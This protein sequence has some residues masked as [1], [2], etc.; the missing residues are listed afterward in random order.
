[1]IFFFDARDGQ[2]GHTGCGICELVVW[3]SVNVLRKTLLG[4]MGNSS[5]KKLSKEDMAFLIENTNFTRP[6]IKAWYKGFMV[7]HHRVIFV[8]Y[9][10]L[11]ANC[12]ILIFVESNE[13]D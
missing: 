4:D 9:F 10:V 6:Q 8:R 1:V 11:I 2:R 13:S 3:R 7:R 5:S 12:I